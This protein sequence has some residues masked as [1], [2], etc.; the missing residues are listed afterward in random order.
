MDAPTWWSEQRFGLVVQ[1]SIAAVPAWAPIGRDADRYRQYLGEDGSDG[2]VEVLAHHRDRWGHVDRFDDF[3]DL[4]T[5]EH[6]DAEEWAG[7]AV[8]AGMTHVEVQARDHDGWCWWDA[9]DADRTTVARGPRRDVLA[10]FASACDDRGLRFTA[11]YSA[12]DV[13]GRDVSR[14]IDPVAAERQRADLAATFGSG[15]VL[16]DED[17][18]SGPRELRRG[19]GASLGHNRAERPEHQL[20]AFDV[21]DVLTEVVARGGHLLLALGPTSSGGVPAHAAETLRDAGAWIRDHRDL[22]HRAVPWTTW[23]DSVVRYLVL[24]G[25]LH[26]IDLQGRGV[27]EA[28]DRTSHRVVSMTSVD[29]MHDDTPVTFRHDEHGVR[30]ET[31]RRPIAHEAVP[32]IASIRTFRFELVD[33]DAPDT[34][35]EPTAQPLV[36]LQPLLDRAVAGDIVQLGDAH[37]L[38]PVTVPA[39]VVLRGLGAGRTTIGVSGGSPLRL[40]R[41]ARLEHV[42]VTTGEADSEADGSRR[43]VSVEIIGP[44]ATVLGCTIDGEVA[45]RADGAVIRATGAG[46]ISAADCNHLTVSRCELAGS[47][48]EEAAIDLI[49]GDDHEI[50]SCTVTGHRCAVRARQTVATIVRGCT[51]TSRWWG[52]RLEATERAHIHGNRV[53]LTT[54]AVDVDGGSQA[55]V[56]GNAVFDGDSGCVLQRGAAGCQVSGNYWQRCRIGLL[57][58]GATAVHEQDN[59]TVDLHDSDQ[60]TIAGP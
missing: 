23:G 36:A 55:L 18:P 20:T 1:N 16:L 26:A 54:R 5:F 59:I 29:P 40:D 21:V 8:D 41:N 32:S 28:I 24:D 50:D 57:A 11:R 42:R 39:G 38:G 13:N 9:P 45:A 48:D 3:V 2:L 49:G 43:D 51:I 56:D 25:T 4:L 46:R 27:F 10:E 44:F 52:I 60:A 33:V 35:F 12:G 7:L 6:F 30:I 47:D 31:D 14:G 17:V 58:W 15:R 37:Y 22:L 19:L 34:L 53:S